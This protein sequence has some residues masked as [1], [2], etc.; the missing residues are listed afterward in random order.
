MAKI[1]ISD[2]HPVDAKPFLHDLISAPE[3]TK[4]DSCFQYLWGGNSKLD[5]TTVHDGIN[6]TS[7]TSHGSFG[8]YD[9]NLFTL[10]FSRLTINLIFW[11]V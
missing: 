6:N 7:S 1:A 3:D 10:D 8:L 5:L 9:N 4:L 11:T 2:L